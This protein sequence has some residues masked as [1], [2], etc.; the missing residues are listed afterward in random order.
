MDRS[1]FKD[2]LYAPE[3]CKLMLGLTMRGPMPEG[4]EG[5]RAPY[6][7]EVSIPNVVEARQFLESVGLGDIPFTCLED[8][9]APLG[10][11]SDAR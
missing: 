2:A 9:Y 3:I 1:L 7:M 8:R 10:V 6:V 4:I 11:R 5:C